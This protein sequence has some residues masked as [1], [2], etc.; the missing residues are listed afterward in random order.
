MSTKVNIKT[1]IRNSRILKDTL[2]QLNINFTEE[3]D[4]ITVAQ[5]YNNT[6]FNLK[7]GS[8]DYDDM[9][10]NNVEKICRNY[11][12]N[13]VISNANLNNHIVESITETSNND[14]I[15]ELSY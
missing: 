9:Q 2:K 8:I 10:K 15:I 3:N 12:K 1:E 11:Q 14:I 7:N 6:V 5:R 13:L 4:I